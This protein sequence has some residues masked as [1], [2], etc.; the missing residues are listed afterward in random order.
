MRSLSLIAAALALT[1]CAT[2]PKAPEV[3]TLDAL[4]CRAD[5]DVPRMGPTFAWSYLPV[6]AEAVDLG[7]AD[8]ADGPVRFAGGLVLTGEGAGDRRFGGLSDLKSLGDG[9][10]MATGD[11]G[12]LVRF[13]IRMDE[14]GQL[15]SAVGFERAALFDECGRDLASKARRDRDGYNTWAD[16]EGLALTPDGEVLV[17]FEHEARIWR[18]GPDGV[19]GVV[20][21]PFPPD[22]NSGF[23]TL[24]WAGEDRFWT[25]REAGGLWLCAPDLCRPVVEPPAQALDQAGQARLVALDADPKGRGLFAMRRSFTPEAGN[26]VTVGLWT[27]D[28]M[29]A[30][31]EETPLIRL[32]KPMRVD[33]FE[34][35]ASETNADGGVRLYL[36]SDD[37]FNSRDQQTL[38]YAFDLE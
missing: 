36:V 14:A 22:F 9:R 30:G 20:A 12:F 5:I 17:S 3:E 19:R 35:L 8:Y 29:T 25:A 23:E 13:W 6:A 26:V 2:G 37:N 31:R 10:L 32:A 34:G 18:Y 4:T 7:G 21:P 11:E 27:W 15:A 33:N 24:V 28:E 38:L 1:A 16:S